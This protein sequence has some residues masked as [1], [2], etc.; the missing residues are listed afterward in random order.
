[1]LE[2]TLHYLP[3]LSVENDYKIVVI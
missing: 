1:M 2:V 3:I